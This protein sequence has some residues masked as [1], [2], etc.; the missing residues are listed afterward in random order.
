MFRASLDTASTLHGSRRVESSRDDCLRYPSLCVLH[1]LGTSAEPATDG[2]APIATTP[3]SSPTRTFFGKLQS[4]C[5][6]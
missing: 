2:P 3:S 6:A 4:I 5:C 1:C